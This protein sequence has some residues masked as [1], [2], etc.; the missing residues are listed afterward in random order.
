MNMLN[1]FNEIRLA[2]FSRHA[3]LFAGI[4]LSGAA[5][6]AHADD[7]QD[8]NKLFK[9]GQYSQAMTKVNGYLAGKPKDAQARFLKGLIL[10]EQG[11]SAEAIK[12]FSALTEDYPELPEPYNNLAVLYAGQGQY[13]K[14]KQ[15]LEMA[16]R[17]HPSYATAHEN[18]GDIYAKMASQAYDRA[19]QLD[20]SNAA[21][22]TKLA[23]I[24]DLFAGGSRGK[25][26]AG[27]AAT[28]T[29]KPEPA[30]PAASQPAKPEP[31]KLAASQPPVK[32]EPAK[33][34]AAEPAVKPAQPSVSAPKRA[35]TPV[36]QEG[37]KAVLDTVKAW[38]AA[39]SSKNVPA[40]LAFYAG[41]FRPQ[42]GMNRAAWE[43]QRKE[44]I[45]KPKTIQVRISNAT[46]R[47]TDAT[48]ATVQFR[49]SYHADKLKIPGS[50]TLLMV[51]SGDKWLIQEER[52][53]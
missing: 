17:T 12:T 47:F 15:S 21:T 40:Y 39:W 36:A 34:A 53:K 42:D 24:Q 20:R 33:P 45:G 22:Q 1:R 38:A 26:A 10:T 31:A 46:V 7:I 43:G 13:D 6:V 4:L 44:R 37:S 3:A 48:H 25:A 23:M 16:I 14:A 11:Q 27:S 32:P 18:L 49:Q 28:A 30:A 50:K 35:E 52:A 8:A 19:L 9:Q 2:R 5:L 41:D 29:T 51:K